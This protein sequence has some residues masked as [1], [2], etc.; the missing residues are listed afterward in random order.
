MKQTNFEEI[1]VR[2]AAWYA[3]GRRV[4]KQQAQYEAAMRA[5]AGYMKAVI[6]AGSLG[7]ISQEV[8]DRWAKR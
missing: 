8:V 2:G 5:N 1:E 7:G 3:E 4:A 6:T